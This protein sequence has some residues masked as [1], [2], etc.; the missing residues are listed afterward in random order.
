MKNAFARFTILA[1][2]FNRQHIQV[3]LAILALAMLV[4]GIGA[5]SDGG[6]ISR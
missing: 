4:L 6:G 3:V 1:S 2:K 5:P